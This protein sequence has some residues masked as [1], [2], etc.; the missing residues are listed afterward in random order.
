MNTDHLVGALAWWDAGMCVVPAMADGSKRPFGNWK[1]YQ[2][3]RPLRQQ[4][5][6]WFNTSPNSGVGLI[7]GTVSGGLEMLEVEAV[8][9]GSEY[10]DRIA[11]Q[12]EH[13]GVFSLWD[14]IMDFG[15]T[16][17]TP[18]G[19]IHILY[20]ITDQPVPGNQKIAM[21]STGKITFAETRGEGGFVVV[22]PSSGTVH[23]S[24]QAWTTASGQIGTVPNITW[25][26]RQKIH[27][28]L[29]AA[30]D[31]RVLPEYVRPAGQAVYDRSQ[32][33]RP[34]DAFN[35]DP[36]IT[37]HDILLRNGWKYLGKS[38]GQ[39]KYVH[40]ASSN[41]ATQSACTGHQGSPNLY[42]WSGMPR[43]DFYD[44]FG[45]L[46]ALEFNG[47]FNAAGK[48]LKQ[49]GYGTQEPRRGL[50]VDDWGW[51]ES[52]TSPTSQKP[53]GGSKNKIEQFSEKGVGKYAG[54]RFKDDVRY[55]HQEKDWR[56]YAD[57]VWRRDHQRQVNRMVE[58]VS[59]S[60]DAVVE[61][62]A[63]RAAQAELQGAEDAKQMLDDAKKMKTFAKSI[64]SRRGMDA[65]KELM[66]N[67]P[68]IAVP[69]EGFDTDRNVLAMANGT[70]D[71]N[72]MKLREHRPSDMLTKE[73]GFAYDPDATA[74]RWL[75]YL[76]EV[77]PDPE[78]RLYLQR[79]VG[80]ALLGD[81]SEGAFFVLWG[82]TG[83]G[84]SQFLEVLNAVFGDYGATAAASAF[85]ES[86]NGG[87][88]RKSNSL[89]SL[90]GTRAVLTSETSKKSSLDEELIKRVTG[91]DTVTSFALYEAEISWKPQFTMFMGTNFKPV[92]DASDG[93]I[94]RRVKP[95]HFP[96]SFFKDNRPTAERVKDL[97][98]HM[99]DTELAGIFNWVLA[100][101]EA[102]RKHGLADPESLIRT[103]AEYREDSDPVLT[104]LTES[105]EEGTLVFGEDQRIKA[106]VAYSVFREWQKANN[107]KEFVTQTMFGRRLEALKYTSV[108]SG[109]VKVRQGFAI[110]PHQM[111]SDGFQRNWN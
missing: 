41:M 11:D 80:M 7:C 5:F 63:E 2:Q 59:D 89:H 62:F 44:K 50:N 97:G 87:D 91:G 17:I 26:E 105:R 23:K 10:W 45:V 78:I 43:E 38:G 85:R 35:D 47:D 76:E 46:T 51:D 14:T 74:D 64:A 37:I 53:A 99:I 48:W 100:G 111:I 32:G 95:V 27:A 107:S 108:K 55:V 22:A 24:G 6:T 71:L 96:M 101:V 12:M 57:G 34:G 20:R 86:R 67:Y 72:E 82:D 83:C 8:R 65:V 54:A 39:D 94:W 9:M 4:V 40:P 106:T 1:D 36:N 68:G 58:Q 104:W 16:E 3:V 28:A 52:E 66:G 93:A 90:R 109:G 49:Q 98:Q 88:S 25:D 60:L 56:V 81:T 77:L 73:L 75:Q 42:A 31:E 84:K 13:H 15:Y 21:D 70:F 69:V 29:K 79:A 19:G 30:L 102:Y 103:V 92:L 18:S 33:D 61:N 110:N